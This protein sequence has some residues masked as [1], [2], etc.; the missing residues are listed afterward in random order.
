MKWPNP[1]WQL[2]ASAQQQQHTIYVPHAICSGSICSCY[3]VPQEPLYATHGSNYFVNPAT[4]PVC[5]PHHVLQ[6]LTWGQLLQAS[7]NFAGR[8]TGMVTWPAYKPNF[9]DCVDHFA[10]HAGGYAVLKGIQGGM[11]LPVEA[12]LPSFA[13][14]RDYGNTSSSTTWYSMSYT[15]TCGKIRK[16]ETIMQ[17]RRTPHN[18]QVVGVAKECTCRAIW[19]PVL[20]KHTLHGML[21][22]SSLPTWLE[23]T[24]DT[25][26]QATH[27]THL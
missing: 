18:P 8:K 16:G 5:R 27:T 25:T 13:A 11:G 17:V 24:S 12:V 10:I 9:T 1:A 6:I 15:E 19:L 21:P 23:S 14:L 22:L 26:N 4:L 20:M 2:T 3:A 7:V